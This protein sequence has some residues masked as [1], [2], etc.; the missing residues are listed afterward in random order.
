MAVKLS[1]SKQVGARFRGW[2]RAGTFEWD[3]PCVVT[4]CEPCKVFQFQI[5]PK[6]DVVT[7]WRFDF[8]PN[9]KGI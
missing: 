4:E 6:G 1:E 3:A 5:P 7:V 2:N 8:A 9:G